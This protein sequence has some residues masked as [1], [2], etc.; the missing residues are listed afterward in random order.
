MNYSIRINAYYQQV[1]LS[2]KNFN[3]MFSKIIHLRPCCGE[4]KLRDSLELVT[5]LFPE[6]ANIRGCPKNSLVTN[7]FFAII[8][9]L[10]WSPS[11]SIFLQK[12]IQ[13]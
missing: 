13:L 10:K 11:S 2:F 12:L 1:N 7:I 5:K 9:R 4:M 8:R 3:L 6:I